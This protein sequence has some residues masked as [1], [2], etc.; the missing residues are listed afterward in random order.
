MK[1]QIPPIDLHPGQRSILAGTTRFKTI[2]AGRRFGKTLL[3]VEWLA[4]MKGGAVGRT[5]E[6]LQAALTQATSHMILSVLE[7]SD[8]N[9]LGAADM[10]KVIRD[11]L[12]GNASASEVGD[13]LSDIIVGG[14][15]NAM[16]N[17]A[18]E[19]IAWLPPRRVT[20]ALT[21]SA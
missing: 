11:G 5:E 16:A 17:S 20:S 4:L 1:I 7:A 9:R 10:S 12:L 8:I 15:Y 21:L 13:A 14:I 2:A 18:A 3:A 19:Q 6:E